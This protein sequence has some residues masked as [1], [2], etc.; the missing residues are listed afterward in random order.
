[1]EPRVL[2]SRL[3]VAMVVLLAVVGSLAVA[4]EPQLTMLS[5]GF[6]SRFGLAGL[7]VGV[8][9]TD[10]LAAT[11][12]PLMLVAYAGGLGFWP[13]FVVASSASVLAGPVGW[14]LGGLLGRLSYVQDLFSRYKIDAFLHRYGFWSVA[15]AAVTPFPFSLVTWAS[16]AVRVPLSVV[17][18]GSL[19]RIP[20]TLFYLSIIVFGWDLLPALFD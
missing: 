10:S 19:F 8:V 6:V 9:L 2:L 14:F 17:F 12:E 16:G 20:K 3:A 7:F 4:L 5:E 13:V 1:M 11:N 18:A 15:M